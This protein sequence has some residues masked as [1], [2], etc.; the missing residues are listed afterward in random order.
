MSNFSI[1]LGNVGNFSDRFMGCGYQ[2]DYR[3]DEMFDRVASVKG[4][5]G[6]ELVSNWHVSAEN[7]KQVKQN[8]ERTGLKLV[9]IIPD[10]FG[11]KKYGKGAFTSKDPSVR[12]QAVRETKEMMDIAQFL[13]GDLVSL[14]PGQDGYDYPFQGD[15]IQERTWF[16]EGVKE[17]C[18]YRKDVRVSIEYKQKEPRNFSYP[19]N[20]SSTLLMIG[21]IAEPNCGVTIDYG[22]GA[23][24]Y[25]NLAESVAILKKYGDKLFHVHMN[26]NYGF[27]DDDMITGSIHTIPY[28]EFFYW[29]KRTGYKGY[30]S[31]DQYPY[32]ED[33]RDA[34]NESVRWFELFEEL[35]AN[36]DDKSIDA[37]YK[38]G[39]AVDV[40]AYMR[41]LLFN[42]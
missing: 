34:C 13:G 39:S 11:V 12:E 32:R 26:D 17:C 4:V 24:A 3:L 21:K 6:V 27:W 9:S 36:I 19:S 8:L 16:E 23:V 38:S 20:V 28:V 33:G 31:T 35:A 22:H 1:I 15:Y 2:R 29:L 7:V 10:H 37:L 40:S 30:I 14:W 42:R 25:E 5:T 41:K 18:R